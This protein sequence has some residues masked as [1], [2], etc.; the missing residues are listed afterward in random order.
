MMETWTEMVLL[1]PNTFFLRIDD[2]TVSIQLSTGLPSVV[3]WSPTIRLPVADLML[4]ERAAIGRLVCNHTSNEKKQTVAVVA[5]KI[6][7]RDCNL[8][9][10]G[11]LLNDIR[12]FFFVHSTTTV[13]YLNGSIRPNKFWSFEGIN[14]S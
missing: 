3:N 2:K 7:H 14:T 12:T 13:H 5:I 8:C 1:Y 9:G 10:N 11:A 4:N 6:S